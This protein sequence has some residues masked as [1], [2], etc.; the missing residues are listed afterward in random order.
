MWYSGPAIFFNTAFIVSANYC[1]D[2]VPLPSP[3]EKVA[4]AAVGS[5]SKCTLALEHVI[6]SAMLLFFVYYQQ[7][8]FT[9]TYWCSK[10]EE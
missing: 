8:H 9:K 10:A 1:I 7:G 5:T 2:N 4:L 6:R 3:S